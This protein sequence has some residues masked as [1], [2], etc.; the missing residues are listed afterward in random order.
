VSAGNPIATET[1]SQQ[2]NDYAPSEPSD[3]NDESPSSSSTV[4]ANS[5]N[6]LFSVFQEDDDGT[7]LA[8]TATDA[9]STPPHGKAWGHRIRR[10]SMEVGGTTEQRSDLVNS[11]KASASSF[12]RRQSRTISSLTRSLPQSATS[13]RESN[14]EKSEEKENCDGSLSARDELN[15]EMLANESNANTTSIGVVE[16]GENQEQHLSHTSTPP[17][18]I[19]SESGTG[20]QGAIS[21]KSMQATALEDTPN[22]NAVENDNNL[23]ASLEDEA[24]PISGRM[25]TETIARHS[26]A[27]KIER[28][29]N[30]SELTMSDAT[31]VPETSATSATHRRKEPAALVL[32]SEKKE[33]FLSPQTATTTTSSRQEEEERPTQATSGPFQSASLPTEVRPAESKPWMFF[34]STLFLGCWLLFI[35]GSLRP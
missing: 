1:E 5:Q 35:L 16:E 13:P 6:C 24:K 12:R 33:A 8:S 18:P 19:D 23:T 25:S 27:I 21:K 14:A 28:H 26:N 2:Q 31:A 11:L 4:T 20:D 30:S 10:R 15:G 3:A 17:V 34:L 9:T 29:S 22:A 32:S 7:A